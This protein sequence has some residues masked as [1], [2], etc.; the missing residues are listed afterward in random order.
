MSNPEPYTKPDSEVPVP[1]ADLFE[2]HVNEAYV[3]NMQAAENTCKT[4]EALWENLSKNATS[5]LIE[6]I[7]LGTTI[8]SGINKTGDMFYPSLKDSKFPIAKIKYYVDLLLKEDKKEDYK[9]ALNKKK[10]MVVLDEDLDDRVLNLTEDSIKNMNEKT[11]YKLRNM[12]VLTD[13]EFTSV[14]SGNDEPYDKVN[15]KK[16]ISDELVRLKHEFS[17]KHQT[18]VKVID[19]HL[20][21]LKKNPLVYIER[22]LEVEELTKELERVEKTCIN[23]MME[24]LEE[25]E[26]VNI[27]DQLSPRPYFFPSQ[28]LDEIEA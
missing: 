2:D 5:S 16:L 19:F 20:E 18:D 13:E 12:K 1:A 22:I 28:K 26:L 10:S 9:E 21:V 8:V 15:K 25:P 4:L 11:L 17:K 14:L 7:Q 24:R 3:K 6:H 27:D 23:L